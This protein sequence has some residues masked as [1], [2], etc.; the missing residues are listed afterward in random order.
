[1]CVGGAGDEAT[2]EALSAR[3]ESVGQACNGRAVHASTQY[4][5]E[6]WGTTATRYLGMSELC[7]PSTRARA[8]TVMTGLWNGRTEW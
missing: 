2:Q 4:V 3:V 6:V 1:M 5:R 7:F 8:C